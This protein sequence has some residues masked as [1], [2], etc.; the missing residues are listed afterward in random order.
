MDKP[1][2]TEEVQEWKTLVYPHLAEKSMNMIELENK[3]V[4]VVR[5]EANKEK[6]KEAL[7]KGFNIKVLKVNTE[8]TQRGEKRAYVKLHPD[9]SALDIATRMGM[10]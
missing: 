1:K 5:R 10:I 9:S 6:I 4:F 3:L 8:I 7:E 2:D